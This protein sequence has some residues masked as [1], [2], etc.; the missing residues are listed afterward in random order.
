MFL[1]SL[2]KQLSFSVGPAAQ[3]LSLAT[4]KDCKKIYNRK[5]IKEIVINL[6]RFLCKKK[7]VKDHVVELDSDFYHHAIRVLK[8]K[9]MKA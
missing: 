6:K 8:L 7:L 3:T 2:K 9:L 4:D 5:F 1:N